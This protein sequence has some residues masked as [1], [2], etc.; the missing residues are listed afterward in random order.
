[1]AISTFLKF[2]NKCQKGP[3]FLKVILKEDRNVAGK[4]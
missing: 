1:M 2:S 3:C 4:R